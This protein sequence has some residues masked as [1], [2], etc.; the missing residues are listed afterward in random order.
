MNIPSGQ[1]ELIRWKLISYQHY[2]QSM[3][4]FEQPFL[5]YSIENFLGPKE[6]KLVEDVYNH[7][8]FFEKE[9]DLFHFYQ[10]N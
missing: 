10:T 7:F 3:K 5:H 4:K 9:S 6:S 8:E 2:Y 1:I